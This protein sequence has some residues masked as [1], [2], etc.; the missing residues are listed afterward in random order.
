M[1]DGASGLV[2]AVGV[3]LL[4]LLAEQSGL[5]G[6]TS[7]ALMVRGF[8]PGHD[9]GQVLVDVAIGLAMGATS[10]SAAMDTTA[11]ASMVT[12]A[13]ASGVTAWRLFGDELDPVMPD[14]LARE[15]ATHRRR[16]WNLLAGHPGGF[17]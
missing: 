5:R 14:R 6:H 16:M 8:H 10:V 12:G 9:R 11:G 1:T 2:P 4:R 13:I 7:K 17:P 15:R 3:P